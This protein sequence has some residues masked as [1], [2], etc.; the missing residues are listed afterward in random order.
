[1]QARATLTV[2]STMT[3]SE[4]R[5]RGRSDRSYASLWTYTLKMKPTGTERPRFRRQVA[6]VDKPTPE[7]S[8][9]EKL[10]H[11]NAAFVQ[12]VYQGCLNP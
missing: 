4:Q 11:K 5:Q 7:L 9:L 12:A 6:H 1:M 8:E 10:H 3:A 2:V